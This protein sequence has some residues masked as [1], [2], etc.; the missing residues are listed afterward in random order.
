MQTFVERKLTRLDQSGVIKVLQ[1]T[2]A[3][4]ILCL[5]IIVIIPLIHFGKFDWYSAGLLILIYC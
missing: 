3:K 2:A 1:G 4:F 5:S